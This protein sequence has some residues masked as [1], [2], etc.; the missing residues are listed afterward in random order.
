VAY[1][2]QAG[3]GYGLRQVNLNPPHPEE[4]AEALAKAGVSK[5]TA[6]HGGSRG[7][8]RALLTMRPREARQAHDGG[9]R[10]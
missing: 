5:D 3:R 1:V 2:A 4:P 9:W 8:L 6:A 7:A 10:D